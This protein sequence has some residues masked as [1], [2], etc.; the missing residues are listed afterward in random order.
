MLLRLMLMLCME[1]NFTLVKEASCQIH[2]VCFIYDFQSRKP[3]KFSACS[4]VFQRIRLWQTL[5][6]GSIS[7][8]LDIYWHF[9]FQNLCWAKISGAL[10]S[11]FTVTTAK[12]SDLNKVG[13]KLDRYYS[14][15]T[16]RGLIKKTIWANLQR[17][18]DVFTFYPR[19]VLWWC[20]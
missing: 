15:I 3:W 19:D 13:T 18:V 11:F 1:I 4:P 12:F 10:C 9:K 8:F 5:Q 20:A 16:P 6:G 17:R 2:A 7:S 14:R